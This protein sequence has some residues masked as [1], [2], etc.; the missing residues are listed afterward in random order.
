MSDIVKQLQAK[1]ET[2]ISPDEYQ[3]WIAPL[4][5]NSSGRDTLTIN[6]PNQFFLTWIKEHYLPEINNQIGVLF[7]EKFSLELSCGQT[8]ATTEKEQEKTEEIIPFSPPKKPNDL[9]KKYTFSNFVVGSSNELAH[10]AA[11]AVASGSATYNPLFI[12]GDS[13]LG[14]TH[15]ICSIGN[16]MLEK[17]S[18]L[19]LLYLSAENFTNELIEAVRTEKMNA[20]RNKYRHIDALLIDDI[21]F[22]GG[23]ERTQEEFFYTFNAL[24]ENDKQIVITSDKM[25]KQIPDLE[26]RLRSR[27]E[28]GLFADV[29]PPDQETK[30]AILEKKAEERNLVLSQ[31]ASFFIASDAESNIR[32]LEGY[33]SRLEAFSKMTDTPI[34]LE[35]AQ[36]LL[37]DIIEPEKRQVTLEQILRLTAGFFNVKVSDLKSSKKQQTF[38]IPRQAAMYLARKL[39]PLSTVEIG[40][41]L[42]GRDHSTVIH[43]NN[44]IKERMAKDKELAKTVFELEQAVRTSGTKI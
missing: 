4:N 11:T 36:N 9:N 20:F 14:K 43:A 23:K 5:F 1:L 24:Y 29:S 41:G 19:N 21:Q 35:M 31:E 38:S 25:P 32:V 3:Q 33:L 26:N 17:E 27:F 30:V 8:K 16:M 2:K 39:T 6:A 44:K 18:D 10:A 42:G 28:G 40:K 34:T 37:G 12:Y 13:G 7:G 15:L 22:I